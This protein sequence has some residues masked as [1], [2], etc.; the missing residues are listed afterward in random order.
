MLDA[1]SADTRKLTEMG[2]YGRRRVLENHDSAKEA[3]CLAA[4]FTA[5]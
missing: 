3:A 4:L 1:L 5:A 2:N